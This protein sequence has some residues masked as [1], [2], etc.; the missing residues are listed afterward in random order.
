MKDKIKVCRQSCYDRR[1]RKDVT[2][3]VTRDVTR[4][5]TRDV[6]RVVTREVARDGTAIMTRD[7]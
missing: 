7:V 6:T 4:D 1:D 5:A 2:K 3:D